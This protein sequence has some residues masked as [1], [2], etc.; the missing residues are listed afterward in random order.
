MK[1]KKWYA[2]TNLGEAES[3][4]SDLSLHFSL[5][6]VCTVNK[7]KITVIGDIFITN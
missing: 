2:S 5:K 1:S 3:G 4:S 7:F 6:S